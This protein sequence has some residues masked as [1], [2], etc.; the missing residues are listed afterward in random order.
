M[1][2]S[3]AVDADENDWTCEEAEG[4]EDDGNCQEAEG[5]ERHGLSQEEGC[6]ELLKEAVGS[7]RSTHWDAID[8]E[9]FV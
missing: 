1:S 6:V 2:I 4:E 7:L 5:E 3:T 9:R 8:W